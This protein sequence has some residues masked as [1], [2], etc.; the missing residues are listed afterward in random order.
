MQAT[1]TSP[2]SEWM[3]GGAITGTHPIYLRSAF[4]RSKFSFLQATA[5]RFSLA[6]G[7]IHSIQLNGALGG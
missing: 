1:V 2:R 5:A 6:A 7:S 4:P 3:L